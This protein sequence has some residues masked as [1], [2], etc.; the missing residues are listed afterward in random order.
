M[1]DGFV[2]HITVLCFQEAASLPSNGSSKKI[3]I[4]RSTIKDQGSRV[5]GQGSRI[6]DQG[7]RIKD[8][9]SRIKDQGSRIK[10]QGSRIKDQGSK[11]KDQGSRSHQPKQQAMTINHDDT[12][13]QL[14]SQPT[15][16]FIT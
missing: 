2:S 12:I 8:Q 10:D 4:P 7:S 3:L 5:K 13:T 15:L 16:E 6:K 9:R 11:I 14:K 1:L